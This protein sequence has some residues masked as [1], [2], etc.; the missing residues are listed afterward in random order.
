MIKALCEVGLA[1]C[2]P[3]GNLVGFFLL[4]ILEVT[5]KSLLPGTDQLEGVVANLF[6]HFLHVERLVQGLLVE[7]LDER[8]MLRCQN[9]R[10]VDGACR[11]GGAML[12]CQL[13]LL[14]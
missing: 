8:V 5:L 10:F 1:N 4:Q 2:L 3:V 11:V 12:P 6:S 9:L 7:P 14:V 13:L